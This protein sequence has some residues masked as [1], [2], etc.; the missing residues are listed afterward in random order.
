MPAF[1]AIRKFKIF[2]VVAY[3]FQDTQNLVISRR[4]LAEND[5][6]MYKDL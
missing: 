2:A 4:C 6:E 3:V 5:N 1:N